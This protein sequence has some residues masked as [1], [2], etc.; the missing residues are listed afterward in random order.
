MGVA[1]AARIM[2]FVSLLKLK[3]RWVWQLQLGLGDKTPR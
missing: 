3:M 1:A 2:F